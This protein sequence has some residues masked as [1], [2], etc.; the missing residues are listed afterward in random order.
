M[1]A[2]APP[3]DAKALVAAPKGAKDAPAIAAPKTDDT[4]ASLAAGGLITTLEDRPSRL[5][6][7][8]KPPDCIG[9]AKR[10]RFTR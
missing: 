7:F 8:G 5:V 1:G 6:T 9:T 2:E 3:P 10:V 4:N